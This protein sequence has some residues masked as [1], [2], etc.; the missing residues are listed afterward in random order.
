MTRKTLPKGSLAWFVPKRFGVGV[1]P[2][3]WQGY[4]AMVVFVTALV[5]ANDRMP[6]RGGKIAVVTALTLAF[7][8]VVGV[9]TKVRLGWR[10]NGDK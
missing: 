1:T 5:I 10:W 8:A 9:K 7:L 6:T 3:T 4:A 2:A